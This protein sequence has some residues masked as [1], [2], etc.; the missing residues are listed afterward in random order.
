MSRIKKLFTVNP[1]Y[2][3]ISSIPLRYH[4]IFWIT[5]FSFNVLRWGVFYQD[6]IYSFK[7]NL[8][9]FPIHI[10]L[11]NLFVFI[12][13]P[14]LFNGKVFEFF[15]L[16]VLSLG[17]ALLLKFELTYYLLSE[18]VLPEYT[19]VTSKITF[20]YCIQTVLGEVYVITFVTAIKL[21][22][23]WTKQR[24]LLA[25]T[26][27][28][29][30]ENELKYLKSQIQPHFF[31]NT[32]N[33][34]YSLTIDK[35]DKAPDLI[36]KL[37]DLMKYFLYET[38]KKFQTLENEITHIKDYIEIEKLRYK[39]DLKIKFEIIGEIKKTKIKPLLLIPLVENAFKHGARHS[40]KNSFISVSVLVKNKFLIFKVENSFTQPRQKIKEQI[41]GI[42]L[43]NVRKR[44]EINYGKENYTLNTFKE[45]NKYIAELKVKLKT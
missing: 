25:N 6:Y 13:L 15:S 12:F 24:D 10:I 14:K 23:D 28:M 22:I 33:N 29:Y 31:F 35:S 4:I 45:K 39:D 37:S 17:I 2:H 34:L 18:D 26:N 19:E 7:S 20:D 40:L 11:C 44:L 27:K 16:L 32:L 1:T 41:G 5:Y 21:I 3:Q 38:G 30:L 43:S 36:L 8:I 42:G 9:G